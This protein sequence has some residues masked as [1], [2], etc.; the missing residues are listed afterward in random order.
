[1]INSDRKYNILTT[2]KTLSMNVAINKIIKDKKY[3]LIITK[4]YQETMDILKTENI[5]LIIC[6]MNLHDIDF[7]DIMSRIKKENLLENIVMLVLSNMENANLVK[8]ILKFG[9]TDF[10]KTPFIDNELLLK[11]ELLIKKL[12]DNSIIIEQKKQIED[13]LK[14]FQ[15]LLDSTIS[16][17]YIFKDTICVNCNKEASE[18]LGLSSKKDILNKKIFD[19]FQNIPQNHAQLLL[20]DKVEHNFETSIINSD[21]K[22]YELQI[23]ERNV[24]IGDEQL[25]IISAMDITQIKRD[26]KILSQQSKLASMGEMIGNIAHQWRQPLTAISIAASGIKLTYELD[27]EDK[28]E[29]IESLDNIVKNTKF[30]SSTI[31]DFQNFMRNDRESTTFFIQNT[32]NKTLVIIDPNLK[33]EGITI[34]TQEKNDIQITSIQNDIVQVLLN[35]INNAIDILKI[36][37]I[38]EQDRYI[39]INI[40]LDK[41]FV[42]IN[43]LD[44]AGGIPKTIIDKIFEPYFTT[45]N[46]SRGTGLGLYMTHQIITKLGGKVDVVNE[47]IKYQGKQY[48]GAKFTVSL[49]IS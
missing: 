45:K 39:F 3:N 9:A 21:G 29:T 34:V 47:E 26:E 5:S 15:E 7:L 36:R 14:K 37:Q 46:Q 27:I 17:M 35:I 25:K 16:A 19:I 11:V 49:P 30:L 18:L 2:E 40:S 33:L 44:T 28:E 23:R 10:L 8:K 48:T 4:N 24:L 41:E 1:M 43:I 38:E 20:D 13:S 6:D 22:K 42:Y 12:L 32:I 31:E